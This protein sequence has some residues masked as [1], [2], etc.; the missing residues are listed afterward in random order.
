MKYKEINATFFFKQK[1]F[2]LKKKLF[3]HFKQK[4]LYIIN[5]LI[6]RREEM[7]ER[8]GED[9]TKNAAFSSFW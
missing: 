5:S 2:Y 3:S 1:L 9:E 6:Y 8:E 4:K 7:V